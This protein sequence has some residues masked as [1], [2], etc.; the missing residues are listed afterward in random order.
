MG[1]SPDFQAR[2]LFRILFETAGLRV[3]NRRSFDSVP[4]KRDY[5]QDDS[6]VFKSSL[7][8]LTE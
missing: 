1:N 8:S 3:L 2:G 5:A 6:F 4:L 7:R